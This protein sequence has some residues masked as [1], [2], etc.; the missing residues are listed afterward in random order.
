M[1]DSDEEIPDA[2]EGLRDRGREFWN[3]MQRA[4]LDD[5]A[6]FDTSETAALEEACRVLDTIAQLSDAVDRDGH[7]TAGSRG[8][9]VL[10][11]ALSEIRL[12]QTTLARLLGIVKLP[13]DPQERD[14]WRTAR[15]KAGASARWNRRG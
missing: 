12:Q 5:D 15:A 14:R 6:E 13:E 9:L 2:P 3:D 7:T 4:V 10:H 8:Q 1:T 11:P